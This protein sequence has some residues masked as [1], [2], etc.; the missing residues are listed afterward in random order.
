MTIPSAASYRTR[1]DKYTPGGY[2]PSMDSYNIS[3]EGMSC[4][5]CLNH[6]TRAIHSVPAVRTA[7]IRMGSAYIQLKPGATPDPVLAAI[8]DAGYEAHLLEGATK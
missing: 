6:V 7:D 1:L 3:I 8:R 5:H 2:T 4:G